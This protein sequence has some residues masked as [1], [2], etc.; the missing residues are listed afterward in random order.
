VKTYNEA[1][2]VA[3]KRKHI[4]TTKVSKFVWMKTKF[5]S[6]YKVKGEMAKKKGMKPPKKFL[7]N[8][9]NMALFQ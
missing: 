8:L 5:A 6:L 2:K 1:N 4:E 9:R 7:L 3:I